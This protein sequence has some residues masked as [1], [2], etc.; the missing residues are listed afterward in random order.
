MNGQCADEHQ[1]KKQL[2][3]LA[4]ND[5]INL[6]VSAFSLELKTITFITPSIQSMLWFTKPAVMTADANLGRSALS[7]T[8]MGFIPS[9][10]RYLQK[11]KQTQSQLRLSCMADRSNDIKK[12]TV[13]YRVN[14]DFLAFS[15][16]SSLK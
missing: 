4:V 10:F 5:A 6:I 8:G 16:L 13:R 11:Q 12:G 14:T 15:R 7:A 1:G 9:S 2:A 3:H